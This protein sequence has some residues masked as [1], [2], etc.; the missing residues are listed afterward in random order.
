[1][2]STNLLTMIKKRYAIPTL[3]L[4]ATLLGGSSAYA[5]FGSRTF[6]AT[7]F[8]SFSAAEQTAIQKAFDIRQKAHQEAEAVLEA[9]GI[10]HEQ[11]REAMQAAHQ[12]D[13]AAVEAALDA[14][15]YS[16]FKALIAKS[17][18]ADNLTA[19]VFAKLVEIRKLEKA[20]DKVGARELRKELAESG[21]RGVGLG[22]FGGHGPRGA[23]G[24]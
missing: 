1:M 14:N 6:D 7:A 18:M 3:M 12:K 19:E 13:R 8:T 11:M 16:A 15:D 23:H 4:G 5:A 22:G 9:A 24:R 21:F 2:I 17:P 10:T 20:G